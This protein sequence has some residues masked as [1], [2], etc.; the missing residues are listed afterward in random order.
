MHDIQRV[1]DLPKVNSKRC[2]ERFTQERGAGEAKNESYCTD[3]HPGLL[4]GIEDGGCQIRARYIAR[5]F[6]VTLGG[7]REKVQT[8]DREERPCD[9]LGRSLR[10]LYQESG[11]GRHGQRFN[12]TNP[13]LNQHVLC[14][15]HPRDK[16]GDVAPVNQYTIR[17]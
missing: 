8:S 6:L 16:E 12:V 1:T 5:S 10:F 2:F 9:K 14:D 13:I 17:S 4:H 3:A 11:L 7:P 15:P